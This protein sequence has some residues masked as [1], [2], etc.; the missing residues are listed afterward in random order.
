MSPRLVRAGASL[1][2]L[3][4]PAERGLE[5]VSALRRHADGI[6]RLYVQ[7]FLDEVWKPF[8]ESGRPDEGWERLHAT[9]ETLR[10]VAG[11]ALLAVLELAVSERLDVTFGRDLAR[12]VRTVSDAGERGDPDA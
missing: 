10:G 6:A 7:L 12:T 3:G 5:V 8:D 11:D 4:I 2:E 1:V 9:I